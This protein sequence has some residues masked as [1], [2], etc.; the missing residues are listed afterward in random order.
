MAI[1]NIHDARQQILNTVQPLPGRRESLSA[2]LGCVLAGDLVSAVNLPGWD[3][4]GMDGY[5]VRAAD[6]NSAGQNNPIHLRV[7]GEVPAGK[8]ASIPVE[9]LTCLR[10]FTGA[11]IPAG[12]D[13]VV[14]QED[15]RPHAGGPVAVL[16]AV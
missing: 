15:T 14:M 4:S 8:P 7:A 5:A 10:I 16:T 6:V 13:A 3:N 2:A 1:C 12:A 11:P 9:A